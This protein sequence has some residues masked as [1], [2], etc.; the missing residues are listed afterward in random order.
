[1]K[2]SYYVCSKPCTEPYCR[3]CEGGLSLC[4]VCK[5]FEGTLTVDCPGFKIEKEDL[6]LIYHQDLD[7]V[8][9]RWQHRPAKHRWRDQPTSA[10]VDHAIFRLEIERWVRPLPGFYA[11]IEQQFFEDRIE[12]T[13]WVELCLPCGWNLGGCSSQV[14]SL[15]ESIDYAYLLDCAANKMLEVA[16]R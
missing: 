10:D 13:A 6:E 1:M 7:F 8:D 2:H 5:G 12:L 3:W 11:Q 16:Q 15:E 9:G 14:V 4:T